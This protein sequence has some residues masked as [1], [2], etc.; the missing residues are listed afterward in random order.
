MNNLEYLYELSSVT[1]YV[2]ASTYTARGKGG[3]Y[4]TLTETAEA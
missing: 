3:D 2:M 4:K 1:D